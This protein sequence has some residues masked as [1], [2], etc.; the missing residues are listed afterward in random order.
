MRGKYNLTEAETEYYSNII[1]SKIDFLCGNQH[2]QV[3]LTTEELAPC[4][5]DKILESFGWER[6]YIDSNGWEGDYWCQYVHPGYEFTLQ[7]SYEAWSFR[8]ELYRG[9]I[10]DE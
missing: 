5:V 4:Q 10:D 3:D 1:K 6:E 8:M 9:D 2:E 7:L